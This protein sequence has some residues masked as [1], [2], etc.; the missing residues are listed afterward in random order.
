[1]TALV[2]LTVVVIGLLIAGLA[3]YLWWA[4]RC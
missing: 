4:A 2:I 1:M 3:L